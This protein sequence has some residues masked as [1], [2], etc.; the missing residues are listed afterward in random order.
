VPS[1]RLSTRDLNRTLLARQLLLT[2][3][4]R[5]ALEVVEHLVGMQAQVPTSPYVGL[6][7]RIAD[8]EPTELSAL[9]LDR[10]V[11]RMALMR[12]TIHLVSVDDALTLRP[13]VQP[14]L[15]W[16]LFRNRT[17]ARHLE[18]VDLAPVLEL[19]RAFVDEQPRSLRE[20]R[21]V[22]AAE[23]PERDATAL[24]YTVRNLLPT[25]QVTPRGVWG[26]TGIPRLTTLE[27]WVGRS[28][29]PDA[30]PDI[31]VMRYL[32]AFG[33]ATAADV[34]AWSR[35][36]AMREVLDRLRPQL[37]TFRD[38]RGREL[39]DVPDWLLA[40][41]DLPAPVRFLPDYDNVLLGH[42]DRTRIIPEPFARAARGRIGRPSFL[43]DGFLAG[44]WRL[45][46][47]TRRGHRQGPAMRLRIEPLAR[48]AGAE[49][50]AV[51]AEATALL[52]FLLP[53]EP[54]RIEV[55]PPA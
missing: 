18:G 7:S 26:R 29:S 13:V 6:W 32:A 30:S 45:L 44:F 41:A 15:D 37:V 9:L 14:V 3:V 17:Y 27:Q 55:A 43:V 4:H 46:P 36:G 42:A 5:L 12:A 50:E 39:F 35:L 24:A 40:E 23:W 38:E 51:E 47:Q 25:V 20:I 54:P 16:E 31:A 49:R 53:G 10:R 19:G 1:P 28:P 34:Q 2:R 22:M 11:V 52:A 8:F 48:L 33:P 21:R